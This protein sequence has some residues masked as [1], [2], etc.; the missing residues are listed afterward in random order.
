MAN[1]I[2]RRPYSSQKEIYGLIESCPVLPYET[3]LT[4]ENPQGRGRIIISDLESDEVRI[5]TYQTPEEWSRNLLSKTID[6]NLREKSFS[7]RRL[8][9][10]RAQK[11]GYNVL[12]GRLT[13]V[14]G[15]NPG[16][17]DEL[18]WPDTY[19]D[20]TA[21]DVSLTL[22]EEIKEE[23]KRKLTDWLRNN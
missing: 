13:F 12:E 4:L 18:S 21:T 16:N 17:P 5:S 3:R 14:L 10:Q 7:L 6:V 9:L 15:G 2:V 19:A 8:F 22:G 23:S 20:I 1:L 11:E